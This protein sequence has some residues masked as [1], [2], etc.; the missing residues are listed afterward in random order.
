MVFSLPITAIQAP[1]CG[2]GT[3]RIWVL[4]LW[5]NGIQNG[6]EDMQQTAPLLRVL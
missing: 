2:M 4:A 3:P 1:L 5:G 6:A